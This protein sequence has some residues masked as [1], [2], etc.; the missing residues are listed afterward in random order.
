MMKQVQMLPYPK[1]LWFVS[2]KQDD[3][4]VIH[5]LKCVQPYFSMVYRKKKLFEIRRE[6]REFPFRKDDTLVLCEIIKGIATGVYVERK[7]IYVLRDAEQYGL[8][9]GFV[10]MSIK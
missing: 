3:G 4:T 5:M 7:V 8:K 2:N 6:D 10:I 1:E 9:D